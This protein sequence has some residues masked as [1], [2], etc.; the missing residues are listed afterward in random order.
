MSKKG[1]GEVTCAR[2]GSSSLIPQSEASSKTP[3]LHRPFTSLI[4]IFQNLGV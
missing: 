4:G 1:L 3:T 2:P